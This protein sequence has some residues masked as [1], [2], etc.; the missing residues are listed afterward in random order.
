MSSQFLPLLHNEIVKALRR[1]LPY[2]GLLMGGL[3]CVLT[4]VVAN[5]IGKG[6]TANAWGYAALS[7]QLVFTDI[8]LIFVLVFAAMLMSDE[9]R[10][11]TIRAA[12]A[13]PLYR[14]EFYL[15]KAATGLLYMMAMSL[16]CLV[17]SIVLARTRYSFGPVAD[18]L[19]EIYPRHTVLANFLFAW[20]LSWVPLSA[21][22]FYGLFL[23]TIIRSSGAAVA[24]SIGTLYVID[25]TKHLVHLDPYIFTRYIGY[26]WQVLMQIAQGVGYQW[27]P[28][29]WKMLGLCGAYG[30]GAFL[31]GL[32]LFL[33]QD[34]ND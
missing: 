27:R 14:W 19:G 31:A 29:I 8:G 34:L 13:A 20:L 26:S 12:L 5:E 21:I 28:E 15:A 16:V 11:G 30:I 6:N 10:F 25:F 4:W 2:F 9:T 22:V 3:I 33:R 18:S 24:V 1:K 7:M 32:I 17:L 23:S